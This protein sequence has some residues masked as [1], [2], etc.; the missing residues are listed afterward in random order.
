MKPVIKLN[1]KKKPAAAI[2][3]KPS[4]W[5]P[6][7]T[8]TPK[9]GMARMLRRPYSMAL[10][11]PAS[12]IPYTRHRVPTVRPITLSN[13]S[14]GRP[15]E[16]PL[17]KLKIIK[18]PPQ[19]RVVGS[20]C[21][22]RLM[23]TLYSSP[24]VRGGTAHHY[25]IKALRF[26]SCSRVVVAKCTTGARWHSA[27]KISFNDETVDYVDVESDEVTYAKIPIND[28][29]VRWKQVLGLMRRGHPQSLVLCPLGD[30]ITGK[31]APRASPGPGL[32]TL[33]MWRAIA[34]H[35]LVGTNAVL[36]TDMRVHE[37]TAFL[38]R[39]RTAPVCPGRSGA[40]DQEDKRSLGVANILHDC[41]GAYGGRTPHLG[42]EWNS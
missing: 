13:I 34:V 26:T 36:H 1:I 16:R 19:C 21:E 4:S 12:A 9:K 32:L 5:S 24:R 27:E 37:P 8:W 39:G 35:Y 40:S 15:W 33:E 42:A 31:R 17:R 10:K 3:K 7:S 38:S 41:Q 22:H 30:R 23:V 20:D 2:T 11:R 28:T 29:Q 6:K 25:M 18:K 14:N